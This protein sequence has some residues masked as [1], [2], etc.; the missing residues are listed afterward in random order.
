MKYP[1]FSRGALQC[2]SFVERKRSLVLT[3]LTGSICG[4]DNLFP[5]NYGCKKSH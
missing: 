4:K 3:I 5:Q 2:V 1:F